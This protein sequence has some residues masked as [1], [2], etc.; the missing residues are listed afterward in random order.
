M[1]IS[2]TCRHMDLTDA[3]R[4]HAHAKVESDLID[5]RVESVHVI[6][7]VQRT[8]HKAEVVLQGKQHIRLEADESSEDMYKSI[9]RAVEKMAKQLKKIHDKVIDNHKHRE[10]MGEISRKAATL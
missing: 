2:V 9:D 4:E 5:P 10:P 8:T 7:D 3:L 6:L 1:N